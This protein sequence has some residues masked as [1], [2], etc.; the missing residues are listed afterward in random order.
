MFSKMVKKSNDDNVMNDKTI[1]Y[2]S[3]FNKNCIFSVYGFY[4][5]LDVLKNGSSGKV[6]KEID[7][8]KIDKKYFGSNKNRRFFSQYDYVVT[9]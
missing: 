3:N 9:T 5:A 7:D 8:L 6:S 2:L 1:E 4:C